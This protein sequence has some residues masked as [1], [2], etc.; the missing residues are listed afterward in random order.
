M[1]YLT[2]YNCIF[3]SLWGLNVP[4]MMDYKKKWVCTWVNSKRGQSNFY[5]FF[6]KFAECNWNV[7]DLSGTSQDTEPVERGDLLVRA[8][9]TFHAAD[10][11]SGIMHFSLLAPGCEMVFCWSC[12]QLSLLNCLNKSYRCTCT[13]SHLGYFCSHLCCI[14]F[15]IAQ[16][17]VTHVWENKLCLLTKLW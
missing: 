15:F 13:K 6:K 4:R 10:R 8:T 17:F 1:L 7:R 5:R 11:R 12:E 14:L 3:S 2:L 9:S 16:H